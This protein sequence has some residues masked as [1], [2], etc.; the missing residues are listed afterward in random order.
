MPDLHKCSPP[1]PDRM[2]R[3][4]AV[5]KDFSRRARGIQEAVADSNSPSGGPAAKASAL[6]DKLG[7]KGRVVETGVANPHSG[8]GADK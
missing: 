3:L 4:K 2:A 6:R 7:D 1:P 8:H 5:D